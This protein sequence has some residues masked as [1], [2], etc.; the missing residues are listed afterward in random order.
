MIKTHHTKN[1]SVLEKLIAQPQQ[2]NFFQ[3]VSLLNRY[4]EKIRF[5]SDPSLRFPV[6]EI[7]EI[8]INQ[9]INITITFTGL[10]GA[11]GFLPHHYTELIIQRLQLKDFALKNFLDIFNHRMISLFYKSHEKYHFY[12]NPENVNH[13]VSCL[14]GVSETTV[15]NA[16][17]SKENYLF[18]A[19]YFAHS[20][21]SAKNLENML[22]DFFSTS[23]V[24]TQFQGQWAP[25]SS[26]QLSRLSGK[27]NSW[28]QLG[29]NT[30]IGQ[31]VWDEQSNF[32]ITLGPL[33]QN[34]FN[35]FLPGNIF[36]SKLMDLTKRYI[37]ASL[38]F[39]IQFIL[40]A[41]EIP[42]YPLGSASTAQLG[43]N[44]WLKSKSFM[45]LSSIG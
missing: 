8:Q 21:R 22:A 45:G 35:N 17:L 23:V 13:I 38:N 14:T 39:D 2:F 36:L 26:S 24:I 12:L 44:I 43:S 37:G 20:K 41:N 33:T 3:A 16:S 30:I 6:S 31:K 19:V 34:Q 40:N 11:S 1:L 7:A 29:C 18:Y 10:F 15:E 42:D 9:H 5:K 28:N 27:P 4:D 32:R 25:L